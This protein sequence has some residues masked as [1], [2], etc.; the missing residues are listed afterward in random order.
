MV[1][2]NQNQGRA[3]WVRHLSPAS[4][5]SRR[6]I[7]ARGVLIPLP[8]M[9]GRLG[10]AFKLLTA[11][12]FGAA[13]CRHTCTAT[14]NGASSGAPAC[15]APPGPGAMSSYATRYASASNGGRVN[16]RP[17]AYDSLRAVAMSTGRLLVLSR[18]GDL[19]THEGLPTVDAELHEA[20]RFVSVIGPT[21]VVLAAHSSDR[22]TGVLGLDERG[23]I[24]LRAEV[25]FPARQPPIDGGGGLV[26]VVG[27]GIA[28]LRDG[29]VLWSSP[30]SV[31]I[32]GTSF[33]DGTLAA[34][35][36]S[37]LGLID[38][39]GVVRQQLTV[40]DHSTIV[41]PP[42]IGPDGTIW[43]ATEKTLF[44]AR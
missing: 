17:R 10:V 32:A 29:R 1:V 13:G 30:S 42:A 28:A 19:G 7:S 2:R 35:V 6:A 16:A 43:L 15:V 37:Q 14:A 36:G 3:Y 8:D 25:S 11:V 24:S 18:D 5:A 12:S 33:V 39:D 20:A 9:K 44:A 22:G 27:E 41:T 40:P 4:Q 38:P 26:Y 31:P 34:S 21:V 23:A